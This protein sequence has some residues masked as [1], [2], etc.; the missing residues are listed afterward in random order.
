MRKKLRIDGVVTPEDARAQY[1]YLPF[2]VPPGARRIE[3][4]YHYENQ[5]VGAQEFN[6]G[7]NIDIGV[8]DTRG[9]DFLSG[10]FRGWSGGARSA[11]YIAND[12]ATPGY[13][14]GPIQAGEWSIIFGLSKIE[15]PSR[16]R[17]NIEMDLDTVP[18]E[19]PD[20]E[21]PTPDGGASRDASIGGT[22]GGRW[23]RGDLHAHSEH[24]DG[25]NIVEEIVDYVHRIGLDY[26]ALT[27]HNTISHWDE[28]SRLQQ[29][30]GPTLLIAGEEITMYTGHANVWGLDGWIDFRGSDA[31]RVQRLVEHANQR[32]S[33]FSI[34]HPDSPIPWKHNHVHGYQAIEV[35]N[36]PWRYYNEPA[37]IRWQF[38]LNKGERMVAVGGSDS[39]CVPPAEMTQ[40]NGPGEPC[41]WVW[42]EGPL[43]QK[44]VLDAV[45]AG[46]VFVSEAPNGPMLDLRAD[47]DG[48]GAFATLAGDR[49]EPGAKKVTFRLKYRG[50]DGKH[51]RYFSRK[52]L[53]RDVIADT[54]DFTDEFELRCEGDDYLRVECRGF[55]GRPDRGEVVHALTNPIYW[56]SW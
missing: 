3:V 23:Y 32:G 56:G 27:D 20:I 18:E 50:P 45:A 30:G 11:F 49:M 8:F 44:A 33:M 51:L 47:P 40:P 55:R 34:N 37:L 6:P 4:N 9:S 53:E 54:E 43:T 16:Y 42:V 29:Q 36:A 46:R 5:V 10:G 1:V 35:W 26:F 52:G 22:S 17:V 12:A 25:A 15:Q 7:N 39:H 19:D 38:H 41:T 48:S 14:R 13:L 2:E 31:E 24:S 21:V 28:L